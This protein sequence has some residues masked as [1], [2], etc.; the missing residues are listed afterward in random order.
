MNAIM[1]ELAKL[2]VFLRGGAI[3][4][5]LFCATV[6]ASRGPLN[7]K[8]GSVAVLCLGLCAYMMVSSPSIGIEA[9]IVF[10]VLVAISAIVPVL[11]YWTALE[12][13][14][15]NPIFA[16]W[17]FVVCGLIIATAWLSFTSISLGAV[18]GICV[19]ALF[20]HLVAVVILGHED[21]LIETRRRFRRWFLL[22]VACFAIV[23]T[24]LEATGA[25]RGLPVVFYLLHA[26]VF[27][28]LAAAFLL[29]AVRVDP[30]IWLISRKNA[31]QNG[32]ISPIQR[33][34][35]GRINAAMAEKLWEREGLTLSQMAQA[36]DTQEHRL[37]SAINQ[38]MGHRNFSSFINGYRI[39]RA[40]ELLSNPSL[41]E[42]TVLS[43]AYD[44]GF[45]SLGPFNRAFR[46]ATGQTPTEYRQAALSLVVE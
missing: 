17:Q 24:I 23:I 42:R 25:D 2:E 32:E 18:R 43:V 7:R 36:L 21:D 15:D 1:T 22:A 40:K 4:T 30:T 3:A 28:G 29:W 6:F 34:L 11:V 20:S 19:I 27:W 8:D 12:L 33:A 13:F 10:T 31:L 9:G 16:R 44:V 14:Q 38:G 46:E 5:L 45:A 37:R 26:L 41:P 39:A 35:I